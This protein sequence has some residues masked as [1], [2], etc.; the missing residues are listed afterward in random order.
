MKKALLIVDV[1]NDFC[2]G[3]ALAVLYGNQ[4]VEPLNK[5]IKYTRANR[6]LAV[7][8]RDWH[9][10]NHC[11]FQNQGGPWPPHCVQNTHG[12]E[13]HPG[14]ILKP[15]FE[16]TEIR[17][18]F[19]QDEDSYSAFGGSIAVGW[20]RTMNLEEILQ[21]RK[22]TTVYI[23]GLATDYCVKATALDAVSLNFKTY[24]LLDACRA[25]NVNIGDSLKA[26]I[27][28]KNAGVII[29]ST[30]KVINGEETR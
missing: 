10:V 18:G 24:L 30:E 28:M 13:F 14:L 29:T 23:G 12:A 4:V 19:K 21:R 27:E 26:L 7:A 17:K 25:V 8:S 6:W 15:W 16:E 1:Q 9:P 11:S 3:G 22:I 20:N 2:P 5:M